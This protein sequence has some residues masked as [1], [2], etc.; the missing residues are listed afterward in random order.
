MNAGGAMKYVAVA[1]LGAF[2]GSF[3]GMYFGAQSASE[4]MQSAPPELSV[5]GLPVVA[6]M[7]GGGVCGILAGGIVR[8]IVARFLPDQRLQ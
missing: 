6:G 8:V 7:M 5:C 2:L 4:A 3:V 1:G